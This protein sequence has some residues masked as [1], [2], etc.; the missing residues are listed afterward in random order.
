MFPFCHIRE[1][2]HCR[3]L[4]CPYTCIYIC[5]VRVTVTYEFKVRASSS[6]VIQSS[7]KKKRSATRFYCPD[8]DVPLF[9]PNCFKEYHTLKAFRCSDVNEFDKNKSFSKS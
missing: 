1:D 9:N 6:A 5:A 3:Y 4:S 7:E 2:S 8:C